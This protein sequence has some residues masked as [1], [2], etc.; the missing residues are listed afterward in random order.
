MKEQ[1][2]TRLKRVFGV[3]LDVIV[4]LA[5]VTSLTVAVVI[6]VRRTDYGFAGYGTIRS[7]SMTASGLYVGD[8]VRVRPQDD[9]AKG[10]VIVFYRA[11][12]CYGAAFDKDAVKDHQ[13]WIH[14]VVDVGTDAL[15]RTTYLT[16]GSSNATDDGAYVPQD[17]VLG[18]ATRLNNSTISFINF[19]C[20]VKGIICLVE[21]PCG[22]VLVYLIWDLV[23]FL[24]ADKKSAV[25]EAPAET[26]DGDARDEQN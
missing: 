6:T 7:E 21:V 11:T 20:S 17:F 1:T 4:T 13:I 19:V 5:L 3:L 18:K 10:D 12:E 26:T 25:A 9:Y 23:M 16:K 14:E 8:V 24:T 2:K 22:I 15:G